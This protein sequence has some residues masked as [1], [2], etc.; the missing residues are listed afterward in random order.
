[1]QYRQSH[2]VPAQITVLSESDVILANATSLLTCV[3]Y[4]VPTAT[5]R[6]EKNGMNIMNNSNVSVI[7]FLLNSIGV[8][9]D[10]CHL[11]I[12]TILFYSSYTFLHANATCRLNSM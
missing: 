12:L 9:C 11:P 1:M 8:A 2:T 4:G 3:G 10:E 6:W 7:M 5:I